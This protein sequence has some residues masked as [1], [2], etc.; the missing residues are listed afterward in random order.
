MKEDADAHTN[1]MCTSM[2][3]REL[4]EFVNRTIHFGR[5]ALEEMKCFEAPNV[6]VFLN[7][8]NR[9][10]ETMIIESIGL[11][12]TGFTEEYLVE[13]EK[14]SPL[15]FD[16]IKEMKSRSKSQRFAMFKKYFEQAKPEQIANLS[17][18]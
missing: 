13:I 7:L 10:I 16:F 18:L 14:F 17:Y 11:N 5:A 1:T 12:D 15:H 2:K 8:M 4:G 3:T 9:S 6:D